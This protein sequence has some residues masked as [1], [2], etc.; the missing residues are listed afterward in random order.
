MNNELKAKLE[1]R[2]CRASSGEEV[3]VEYLYD[4]EGLPGQPD[5]PTRAM[6]RYVG[7]VKDG[8]RTSCDALILI[9]TQQHT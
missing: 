9:P 3:F 1:H 7:G 4:P 6:C 2:V 8:S 5:P